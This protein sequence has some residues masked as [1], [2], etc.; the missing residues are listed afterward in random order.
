MDFNG[1]LQVKKPQG[2]PVGVTQQLQSLGLIWAFHGLRHLTT[3]GHKHE[4]CSM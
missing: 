1:A 4:W 3:G 2:L